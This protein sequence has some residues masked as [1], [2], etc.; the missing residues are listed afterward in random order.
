MFIGY[1]ADG[2]DAYAMRCNF[3]RDRDRQDAAA[4]QDAVIASVSSSGSSSELDAKMTQLA[5]ASGETTA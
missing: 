1:Y 4:I 3:K 5:I 2:E